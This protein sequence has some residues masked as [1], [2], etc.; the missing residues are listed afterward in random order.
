VPICNSCF[1]SYPHPRTTNSFL[2]VFVKD[3][4]AEVNERLD[5]FVPGKVYVDDERLKPT[6]NYN[7]ALQTGICE[8]ICMI[9]VYCP[10]YAQRDYCLRE[11][12]LFERI[13]GRRRTKLG[14][15]A[16]Q[17]HF[18]ALV[19]LARHLPPALA[20]TS[21]HVADFS[22]YLALPNVGKRRIR[23]SATL[24]AQ[25]SKL[26]DAVQ[27]LDALIRGDVTFGT[28]TLCCGEVLAPENSVTPW[29]PAPF[30]R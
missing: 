24:R 29:A 18:V 13:N 19:S 15:A 21:W 27:E 17:R 26:V 25:V 23:Q 6:Y 22:G 28:Q 2:D 11:F 14:A 20:Q 10:E 4:I 30:P 7:D 5:G 9:V 16:G 8:S 3:L 12:E 1:V